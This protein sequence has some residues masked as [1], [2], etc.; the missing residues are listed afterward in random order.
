MPNYEAKLDQIF[1]VSG[2]RLGFSDLDAEETQPDMLVVGGPLNHHN[3]SHVALRGSYENF[4]KGLRWLCWLGFPEEYVPINLHLRSLVVMDMQKSNLKRLWNDQKSH[5]SLEELTYLDLSHSTQLKGTPDFFYLPKL[6]KLFLITLAEL[7]L[8]LYTLKLL[9]T[10]I[11]S[12]CSQL[13]RLDDALDFAGLLSLQILKLDNCSKLLSMV[14]LPKKMRDPRAGGT[15]KVG[16]IHMEM[17]NSIPYTDREKIMQGWAVGANAGIFVPG[18]SLPE[19]VRFKNETRSISFTVPE[20][21]LN[22]DLIGFTVWTTYVS[23][24]NDLMSAYTPKITLKNQTK[25]DVWSRNPATDHIRDEVEVSV[26]FGDN[27]A[28][29]ET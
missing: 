22:F 21:T 5:E 3:L 20:P 27:V 14:S 13:E 19:W 29:L 26:Y 4:P 17:C 7:P 23:Q 11:L 10:L 15:E 25:G 1:S 12:G 18:S 6:E 28:I 8:D 2:D 9:E 24:Q 16:V